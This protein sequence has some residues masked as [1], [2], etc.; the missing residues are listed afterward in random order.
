MGGVNS[1]TRKR[2]IKS[3]NNNNFHDNDNSN[4]NNYLFSNRRI[5]SESSN[6]SKSFEQCNVIK[7]YGNRKYFSGENARD[8]FPIDNDELKRLELTHFWN[9]ELWK[10]NAFLLPVD[11]VFS[12]NAKVLDIG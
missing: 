11:E 8:I 10:D 12:R 7:T 3:N 4:D 1:K 9:K 2:K 5:S 6:S